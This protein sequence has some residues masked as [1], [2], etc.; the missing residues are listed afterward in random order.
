MII[1]CSKYNSFCTSEVKKNRSKKEQAHKCPQFCCVV[2]SVTLY[3]EGVRESFFVFCSSNIYRTSLFVFVFFA[4]RLFRFST[5]AAVR[6]RSWPFVAIRVHRGA[7]FLV[8]VFIFS[9]SHALSKFSA[10]LSSNFCWYSVSFSIDG[11]TC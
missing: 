7:L 6:G 10:A 2:F 5:S 3:M 8:F 9:C 1:Y 4:L 11:T